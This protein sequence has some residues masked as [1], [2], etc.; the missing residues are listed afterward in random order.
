MVPLIEVVESSS[1]RSAMRLAAVM[2]PPIY[3]GC[4]TMMAAP[5]MLRLLV[6]KALRISVPTPFRASAIGPEN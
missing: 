1:F 3:S 5:N 2:A 4:C 6:R